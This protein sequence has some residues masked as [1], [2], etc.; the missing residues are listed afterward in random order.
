M[1]NFDII[2]LEFGQNFNR[3]WTKSSLTN[4][5]Y[6]LVIFKISVN[7]GITIMAFTR[8]ARNTGF[9]DIKLASL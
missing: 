8:K 5:A 9:N 4:V 3:I 1:Q 6:R 7:N 2:L